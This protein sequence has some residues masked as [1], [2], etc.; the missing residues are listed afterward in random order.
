[1]KPYKLSVSTDASGPAFP[2]AT[3][4]VTARYSGNMIQ[5]VELQFRWRDRQP[6][7]RWQV[8]SPTHGPMRQR[9]QQSAVAMMF[10]MGGMGDD[11]QDGDPD[12]L[13]AGFHTTFPSTTAAMRALV[14]MAMAWEHAPVRNAD[15][16]LQRMQSLLT[17]LLEEPMPTPPPLPEVDMDGDTYEERKRQQAI[18][19]KQHA[20]RAEK[21]EQARLLRMGRVCPRCKGR[22]VLWASDDP[23]KRKCGHCNFLWQHEEPDN[24]DEEDDL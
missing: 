2:I 21:A 19:R 1:M 13:D 10:G 15:R 4:V 11:W 9:G 22:N 7:T 24:D 17:R 14:G 23:S 5:L 6:V 16:L 3:L 18:K 12:D 20:E 8:G